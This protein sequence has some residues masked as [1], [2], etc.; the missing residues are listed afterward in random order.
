MRYTVYQDIR[1]TFS[2]GWA[3]RAGLVPERLGAGQAESAGMR[4]THTTGVGGDE[5][6]ERSMG[7][8][9]QAKRE[10]IAHKKRERW[11][12]GLTFVRNDGG[13]RCREEEKKNSVSYPATSQGASLQAHSPAYVRR[14]SR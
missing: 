3:R 13:G 12:R 8:E 7:G 14:S 10:F 1:Y 4:K 5:G 2:S 9:K 11:R 6:D